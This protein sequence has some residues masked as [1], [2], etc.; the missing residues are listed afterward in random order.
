[1]LSREDNELLCRVGRGTPM[2]ELLRQYWMPAL[3]SSELPVSDGP[4]KK[5]RLLG[6]DLVAFRDTRG[7][8]GLLAANC[9]HRG[10]SLYFARNEECGLRCSYHGWKY[11]VTGRCVDMP[12][13][14]EESNFKDK[15]RARAYPCR[16][17]NGVIWTYLGPRE[18]PP[19]LPAFEVNTLPA[20]HVYPP[21]MMLEECNW[22]Q[23]LEGDID[24]S[25]IDWVHA[26]RSP[27][28]ERR[29]TWNRD[30]RPR[31]ELLPTD[32]GAC[33]S[34]RRRWDDDGL[35]WHRITQF[36]LPFFSMIA[37][38]D[39]NIVSARAWVPVDDYYNLQFVMRARLDRPVTEDERRQ[40]LDV[41]APWGGYLEPTSDP[42]TRH[43][44]KANIHNDYLH[45]LQLQKE[46]TI[47]IPF[48]GNL[49]DRAM[50]ETMGPIY[51][52]S[53]EHLGTTDAMVIFMR[54]RLIAAARALRDEG[55]LPANVEQPDLC[56]VRPASVLLPDG[57]SW[58]TAT[59]KARQS[60]AGV[61][62]AWVPF[63]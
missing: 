54:R 39:P 33:Y 41:F 27:D 18:L 59:E 2:G 30:K 52:R 58:I 25:H 22:V 46:L 4:P 62:I 26:K 63:V 51:D 47:G 19:P 48:L 37:A 23:A 55:A 3:P 10:A 12:S 53:Q 1:M 35:Y 8:V 6:E 36:I 28:S 20:D 61:P 5:V 29:G 56:R 32:Y 34:A 15:I 43:Y 38:S 49:Q 13:E 24:S 21:L 7:E 57:E 45:D 40:V 42:R 17:V 16:D 31:L 44:T 9:P 11:D 14:P 60:D 50:T